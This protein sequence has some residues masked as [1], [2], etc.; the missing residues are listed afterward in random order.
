MASM[1]VARAAARPV[2]AA[3]SA[4]RPQARQLAFRAPA[5]AMHFHS[6]QSIIAAAAEVEEVEEVSTDEEEYVEE[7]P[8]SSFAEKLAKLQ[9]AEGMP[10]DAAEFSL[11]F[12]WLD[13]NIAVAVDQVF[14]QGQRSPVTEYFFWP[15]KDAWEELKAS[16]DARTWIG[17]RE[18]VLLLNQCTEVINFWQADTRPSLEEARAKFPNSKFQGS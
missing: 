1:L 17:E 8:S 7:A 9:A 16:L 6:R 4:G 2:Q 13:K 10:T 3:R 18:K 5:R 15:R 12:L 11:N 14:H